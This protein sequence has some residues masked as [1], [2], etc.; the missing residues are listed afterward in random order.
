MVDEGPVRRLLDRIAEETTALRESAEQH[1]DATLRSDPHVLPAAK[2]RFVVAI[3]AAIDVGEHIIA[4]EQLQAPESYA[5]VFVGLSEHGWLTEELTERLQKMAGF[6]G[7]LVHIYEDV[8]D[9]RVIAVQRT[10]LDDLDAFRRQIAAG[11][12]GESSPDGT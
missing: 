11:L 10:R 1:D 4:A 12:V 3:E 8:D 7:V 2:Y 5:D 6:R 9:D